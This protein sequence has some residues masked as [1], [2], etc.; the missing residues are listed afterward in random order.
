MSLIPRGAFIRCSAGS[1]PV[2]AVI[3]Q[4][5]LKVQRKDGSLLQEN[6]DYRLNPLF[7]SIERVNDGQGGDGEEVTLAYQIKQK[8]LDTICLNRDG[9]L[10]LIMGNLTPFAPSPALIEQGYLKLANVLAEGENEPIKPESLLAISELAP[11]NHSTII[12]E[13]NEKVLKLFRR[14]LNERNHLKLLI[15]GDSVCCG[16]YASNLHRAYPEVFF[17]ALQAK[18]RAKIETSILCAGGKNSSD[19]L[20]QLKQ[21]LLSEKPNLL[22]LEFVNDLSLPEPAVERNYKYIFQTAR[23]VSCD[24]VVCL[25]HLPSPMFYGQ[26]WKVIAEKPFF[27]TIS[28]LAFEEKFAIADIR[29][30]W[31]HANEEGLQPLW[32]LADR[33]NHPNDY[34]HQIYAEELLRAVCGN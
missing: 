16:A 24:V 20:V 13:Q 17:K 5:T 33:A 7:D 12:R 21:R 1:A 3:L 4:K 11:G 15:C 25:P 26:N 2:G 9:K 32:L 23:D 18:S 10:S 29:Y 22:V 28:R 31:L 19:M 34:G 27:K 8:R 6:R 30:R 14:R